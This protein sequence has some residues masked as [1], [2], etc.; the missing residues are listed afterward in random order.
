MTYVQGIASHGYAHAPLD[1][2]GMQTALLKGI[3][4]AVIEEEGQLH[5]KQSTTVRT[6]IQ[7]T[8]IPLFIT[9]FVSSTAPP[10]SP[11][12]SP[13]LRHSFIMEVPRMPQILF[14]CL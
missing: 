12:P 4:A 10:S 6:N 14:V 5:N 3:Y 9:V 1:A 2:F 8:S 13:P 7:M 11:F